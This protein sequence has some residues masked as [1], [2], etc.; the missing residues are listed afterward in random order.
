MGQRQSTIQLMALLL[1]L[2]AGTVQYVHTV[3]IIYLYTTGSLFQP[4]HSIKHT[5]T[6][7]Y[8][9]SSV[10]PFITAVVLNISPGTSNATSDDQFQMTSSYQIGLIYVVGASMMSGL[11]AALTQRALVGL[12]QRHPLFFSGELAFYG[13]VFLL[14]NLYFNNDIK[15]GSMNL[16]LNWDI[17]TLI[18]VIASVSRS[19]SL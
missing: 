13:I 14:M 6:Y 17:Y 2:A 4:F 12:E 8:C 11:S 19:M 16:F 7:S 9:I 3:Y 18:P 15:D 1:L 10:H 5:H